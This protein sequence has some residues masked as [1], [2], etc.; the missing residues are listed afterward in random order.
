MWKTPTA[1]A[2]ALVL[3]LAAPAAAQQAEP[4]PEQLAAAGDL[5]EA[6]HERENLRRSFE[7]GLEQG[8]IRSTNGRPVPGWVREMVLHF[9][10]EHMEWSELQP[11]LAREYANGIPRRRC[12]R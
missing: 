7:L 10:D 6:G 11:L 5:I 2:L 4:T 1:A 12:A 8:F 9:F 3:A